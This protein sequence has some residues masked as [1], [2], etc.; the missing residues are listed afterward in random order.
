MLVVETHLND[1]EKLKIFKEL[2]DQAFYVSPKF[3]TNKIKEFWSDMELLIDALAG[4][5]YSIYRDGNCDY[6]FKGDHEA[7]KGMKNNALFLSW[8][9]DIVEDY[10]NRVNN[11][12]AVNI[13]EK[14]D[15]QVLLEQTEIMER[16][17]YIAVNI[18]KCRNY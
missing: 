14:E 11:I 7:F 3:K 15:K 8:C 17:S 16:L 5:F 9:L 12:N 18:Q 10:R 2:F 6:V 4:P 1:T 13:G